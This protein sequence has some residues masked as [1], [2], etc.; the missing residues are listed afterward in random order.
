MNSLKSLC[1]FAKSTPL[2]F[3]QLEKDFEPS[4]GRQIRV[5]L[6]VG[7]IRVG[8]GIED[9]NDSFHSSRLPRPVRRRH[10]RPGSREQRKRSPHG[11]TGTERERDFTA[12]VD[13]G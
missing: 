9:S 1:S 10:E 3:D 7:A 13:S 11:N 8:E 12:S 2:A 6:V 5:E 4:L